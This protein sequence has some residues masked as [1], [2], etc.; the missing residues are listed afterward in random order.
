MDQ[1]IVQS[2]LTEGQRKLQDQPQLAMMNLISKMTSNQANHIDISMED[3]A[4]DA[5][6]EELWN[7][8]VAC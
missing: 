3:Q 4:L 2:G 8:Y 1:Q 6:T 7:A 5:L